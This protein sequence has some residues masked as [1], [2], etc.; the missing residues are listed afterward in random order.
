MYLEGFLN[1]TGPHC[2]DEEVTIRLTYRIKNRNERV[3]SIGRIKQTISCDVQ[4]YQT[5]LSPDIIDLV[6]Q[7]NAH[8]AVGN[9]NPYTTG[10]IPLNLHEK[11]ASL[12]A[13]KN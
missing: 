3:R 13:R 2:E 7:K 1:I 11:T 12:P 9:Y 4:T 6:L 8:V 5:E 10:I